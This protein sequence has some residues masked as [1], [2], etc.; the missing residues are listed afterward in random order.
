MI[1]V[2]VALLTCLVS[3][4]TCEGVAQT[5]QTPL[6]LTYIISLRPENPG[7]AW[8]VPPAVG[9]WQEQLRILSTR[10]LAQACP[11]VS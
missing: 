8:A 7:M 3:Q 10:D 1:T 9:Q 6:A 5:F 11:G 4:Y 2:A